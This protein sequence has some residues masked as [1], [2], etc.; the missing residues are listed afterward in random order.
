MSRRAVYLLTLFLASEALL[1]SGRPPRF[2]SPQGKD[3]LATIHILRAG[4]VGG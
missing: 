2:P 1:V 4:H 3:L